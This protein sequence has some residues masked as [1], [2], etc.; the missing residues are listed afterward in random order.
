[1]S[2]ALMGM[3]ALCLDRVAWK[4]LPPLG[5][6]YLICQSVEE[7]ESGEEY[8]NCITG[9]CFRNLKRLELI[10]LPGF[11]RWVANEVCPWYFSLIE[12]LIVKGCPELTELPFSSYTSCYPLET[13]SCVTWFPRLKEL[14]IDNCPKLLSLP[15]IPYSHALCSVT[16]RRAG[17][18]LKELSYSSK[19]YSLGIEGSDMHSLDETI[20]AFHNLTQLQELFIDNC[21]PLAEEHLQMLTALKTLRIHDSSNIFLPIARS[22]ARWQLPV[23]SLKLW[24]CNFSGKEVTRLLTHLPELSSLRIWGCEKITRLDV[25]A[26]QRQTAASLS[27]PASS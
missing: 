8:L 12:V 18:G 10:G 19:S 26:E 7:R 27:L 14:K 11:R 24:M 20:L 17:R 4:L 3:E 9:P 23:T 5:E 21:P 22:D 25:Q 13:D 1:M 6:L 2:Y 16:L 15:P